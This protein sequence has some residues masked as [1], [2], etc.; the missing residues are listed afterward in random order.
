VATRWDIVFFELKRNVV[1]A[2]D[3][4]DQCPAAV[5]AELLAT[6]TAVRDGPPPSFRGGLRWQAMS[7]EL[8]GIYEARDEYDKML[9]RLFCALDRNAPQFGLSRP[10]IVLLGGTRKPKGT[11]V[12]AATYATVVTYR[13]TYLASNPRAIAGA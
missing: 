1:P 5:R 3:F 10:S 12:S 13:A 8:G 2:R 7:G 11:E 9:Y 4:L 6:V